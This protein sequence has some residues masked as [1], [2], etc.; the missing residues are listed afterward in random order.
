MKQKSISTSD[1]PCFSF[2]LGMLT[3]LSTPPTMGTSMA[4][5]FFTNPTPYLALSNL[6]LLAGILG[7]LRWG[8]GGGRSNFQ[9]YPLLQYFYSLF[10]NN[11]KHTMLARIFNFGVFSRSPRF[12]EMLQHLTLTLLRRKNFRNCVSAVTAYI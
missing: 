1:E 7:G 10:V 6:W 4:I 3:A 12:S 9:F 11:F 2:T 8:V 5:W